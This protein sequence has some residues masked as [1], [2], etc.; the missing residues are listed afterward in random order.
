MIYCY[1]SCKK[2][3]LSL[4]ASVARLREVEPDAIVYV[5]NDTRDR[6]AVPDGCREVLTQY[7]RGGT[8][9]GLAAVEGEL[10]T[11]RHI[12][13]VEKTEF[14]TKID[15][16]VWV[17]STEAL[18]P[19]AGNMHN[20]L[21][22]ETAS[23]MLPTGCAYR[24]STGAI[25]IVLQALQQRWNDGAWNPDANYAENLTIYHLACL[26]SQLSVSLIP[27]HLGKLVGMYDDGNTDRAMKAEVVHCGE[28]LS[29]GRRAAREHVFCRMALLKSETT[30]R[31]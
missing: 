14:C 17:N 4:A 30:N 31:K 10:L 25:E 26:S 9:T 11:M 18:Q 20:F 28:R 29:D 7:D 6:A 22:Y 5:A 15:S 21:G 13:S 3:E 1:F 16:D 23:M 27:Y 2:D 19:K 8:G 12:V 24:L